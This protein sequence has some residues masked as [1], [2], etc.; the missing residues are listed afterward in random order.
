VAADS[1][2][3]PL[4]R[5]DANQRE[6]VSAL[7]GIGASVCDLHELG[8]GCPDLLVG[9]RGFNLLLEVKNIEGGGDKLTDAEAEFHAGWRGQVQVVRSI[10]EALAPL[11]LN[12]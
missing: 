7:R 5:V 3:L 11:N 1:G 2:L 8:K 6:I 4:K 9:F 10:D 12:N